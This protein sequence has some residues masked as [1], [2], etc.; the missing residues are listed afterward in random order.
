MFTNLIRRLGQFLA[1]M[2]AKAITSL[3]VS[4]SL[5]LAVV[6]AFV[7]GPRFIQIGGDEGVA[8]MMAGVADSPFAVLAVI[9]VFCALALLGFPQAL[10]IAASVIAFGA[11]FGAVYSWVATMVSASFTFW[12]GRVMGGSWVHKLGDAHIGGL[13]SKL[14]R[15]GIVASALVRVV[16]SAPFIVVN[17]AAGTAQIPY[18]KFLLGTGG[19]IIP[20]ISLIAG[21]GALAPDMMTLSGGLAGLRTYFA[22]LGPREFLLGLAIF[23]VWIGLVFLVRRLRRHMR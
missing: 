12:L 3:V 14:A 21:L 1:A 22:S 18:W 17:A 2:D 8:S 10:L 11:V 15:R 4:L 23:A 16:P 13:L 6:A 20:K 9:G 7:L 5:L 19:G